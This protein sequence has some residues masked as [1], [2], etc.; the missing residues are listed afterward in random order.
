MPKTTRIDTET[1]KDLL[2]KIIKRLE[3]LEKR[4]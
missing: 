2:S 1:N 4:G 3:K